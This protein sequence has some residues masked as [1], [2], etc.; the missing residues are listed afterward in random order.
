M[1]W[2]L[3][4]S[5]TRPLRKDPS[6]DHLTRLDLLTASACTTAARPLLLSTADVEL[7]VR[8]SM[9]VTVKMI[10]ATTSP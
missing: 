10:V 2:G 6:T 7:R 3:N 9:F 5:L 4:N 8:A 1:P